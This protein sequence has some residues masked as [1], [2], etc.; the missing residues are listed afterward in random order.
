MFVAFASGSSCGHEAERTD[1]DRGVAGAGNVLLEGAQAGVPQA[2]VSKL[3]QWGHKER[4][5]RLSPVQLAQT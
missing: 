5:S 3:P 4:H 1:A 2:S